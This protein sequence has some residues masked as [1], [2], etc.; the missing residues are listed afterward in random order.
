VILR[1]ASF[2]SYIAVPGLML[3][4]DDEGIPVRVARDSLQTELTFGRHRVYRGGPVRAVVTLAG[5]DQIPTIGA[6]PGARRIAF[7]R[8]SK[9]AEDLAAFTV[10]VAGAHLTGP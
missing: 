9:H 6:Q 8:T 10:P 2:G 7:V 4:L 5:P 1:A 3:R